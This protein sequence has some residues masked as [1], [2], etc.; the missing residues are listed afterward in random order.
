MANEK[1]DHFKRGNEF[2][3]QGRFF[4]AIQEYDKAIEKKPSAA[5]WYN[6]GTVLYNLGRP[7]D[8]I[9]AFDEAIRLDPKIA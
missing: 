2:N 7:E 8:A 6:K 3:G 9:R 4:E 5:A 1:I